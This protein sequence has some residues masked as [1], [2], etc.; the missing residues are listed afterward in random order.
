MTGPAGGYLV[1]DV[2]WPAEVE[3]PDDAD[4]RTR[5]E[6]FG[7]WAVQP[8]GSH[9]DEITALVRSLGSRPGSVPRTVTLAHCTD[10]AAWLAGEAATSGDSG[11]PA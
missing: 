7:P 9:L 6:M 2:E 1:V 4:R 11:S 5:R 3:C 8:D 10:P